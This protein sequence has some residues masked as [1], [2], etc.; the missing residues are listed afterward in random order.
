MRLVCGR[1]NDVHELLKRSLACLFSDLV[2]LL[3]VRVGVL[4][5]KFAARLLRVEMLDHL[6]EFLGRARAV[7]VTQFSKH[8]FR[9]GLSQWIEGRRKHA[10]G[11]TF[12]G[13]RLLLDGDVGIVLRDHRIAHL[14]NRVLGQLLLNWLH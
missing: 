13:C 10:G 8:A 2:D 7:L 11:W 3:E 1:R 14:A 6:G 4:V 9:V 5:L 12:E